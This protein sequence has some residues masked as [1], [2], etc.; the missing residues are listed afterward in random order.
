MIFGFFL[1]I[2]AG[3]VTFFYYKEIRGQ[4][5]PAVRRSE[6]PEEEIKELVA[7]GATAPKAA[8]TFETSEKVTKTIS[9]G[10]EV[11]IEREYIDETGQIVQEEATEEGETK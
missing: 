10:G 5:E 8:P 6:H 2:A 9:P 11:S 1:Y 7:G 3:V 4:H